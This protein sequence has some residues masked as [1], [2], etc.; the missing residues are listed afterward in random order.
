MDSSMVVETI[1]KLNTDRAVKNSNYA[2]SL[3]G[4]SVIIK[5]ITLPA[6]SPEELAQS[7]QWEA[8]QYIPFHINDVNLDYVPLT[9]PGTGDNIDVILVA[10]KK[11]KINDYTSVISQTGK[12]P[13]LVDVDAF[14]LQNAY[15]TN[16]DVEEG[17][18]LALVN[19]GASVTNVNVL[20]GGSSLFWR[21]ITFGGNQYTDAIQ[22]ELRL[23]FGLAEVLEE[24]TPVGDHTVQ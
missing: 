4:H 7:I 9:A 24:V 10:V 20:S 3:S 5:K 8:E 15:E 2:T 14:A 16:Y 11:E 19:I 6:M 22:R 13:V 17:K 18:V 12:V 21:D 1:Q 23:S